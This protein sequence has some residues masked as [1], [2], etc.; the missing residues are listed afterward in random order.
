MTVKVTVWNRL[1]QLVKEF[2]DADEAWKWIM[3]QD[4]LKENFTVEVRTLK[5]V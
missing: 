2:S 3:Q 5:W 4:G 1:N